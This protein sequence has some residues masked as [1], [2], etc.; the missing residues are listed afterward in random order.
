MSTQITRRNWLKGAAAALAATGCDQLDVQV[1]PQP[2]GFAT[3]DGIRPVTPNEGFYVY[4]YALQPS[5]NPA[6][7]SCEIR[8]DN[9]TLLTLTLETFDGLPVIELEHTLQCIGGNPRNTLISN[10]VWGGL[11]FTEVLAQLGVQAPTANEIVFRGADQYH[12]SIPYSD[13]TDEKLWLVWQMNGEPLPATHGA[14]CRFICQ[15]RYGTKNVKWPVSVDFIQ[16]SYTGF[17]EEGG[18]SQD[19]IY[20]VNGFIF[21]PRE[22]TVHTG[23]VLIFGTAHAGEDPIERVEITYDDGESWEDVEI[24]YSPGANRW[25]LWRTTL[26]GLTGEITARV[27]VTAESGRQSTGAEGTDQ[28]HGYDGGM[29]VIFTVRA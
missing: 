2:G 29:Q 22:G 19:A 28:A 25:T 21:E 4:E 8:A 18:W 27:R 15:G 7:W 14:P 5:V 20:Q 11:P 13:H 26:T 6:T 23:E 1:E 9:V 24:T 10:A 16:G 12:T 17:W 3:A